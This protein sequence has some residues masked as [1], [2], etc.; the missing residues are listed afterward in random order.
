[1][2]GVFDGHG[3]VKAA[4]FAAKNMGKNIMNEVALRSEEGLE[5]AVREGYLT[6]DANFLKL[7]N[8]N[9]G[10]SCVTALIQNGK[11]VVSNAGDCRAVMSRG[12]L[13][14]A[15][16]VDHR[17]SMQDERERIESSVSSYL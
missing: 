8:A 3:G 10:S 2:F 9:G 1:M 7:N 15:L 11:L 6:T 13:A 4:D 5:E 14:E 12:G 17:P 16:T